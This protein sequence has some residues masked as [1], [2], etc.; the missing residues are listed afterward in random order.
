VGARWYL[1]AVSYMAAIKLTVAFAHRIVTGSWPRFG[2]VPFGII[3]V[4]I[5]ISTP[6]Q[7]GE[8]IGWR[9]YALPRLAAISHS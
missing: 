1:F 6:F 2:D 9:G 5:I 4:A 8:E 7:A 3:M